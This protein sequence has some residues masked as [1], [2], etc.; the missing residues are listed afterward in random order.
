MNPLARSPYQKREKKIF[1]PNVS[2]PISLKQRVEKV[3]MEVY[4]M[5][6]CGWCTK[7]KM[8]LEEKGVLDQIK[9]LGEEDASEDIEGFPYIRSVKTGKS[10]SGYDLLENILSKIE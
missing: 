1:R 3:E 7:L 5:E 8:H 10:F 9:L 4:L 2:L 6:G